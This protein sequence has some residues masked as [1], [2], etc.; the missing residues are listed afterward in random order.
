LKYGERLRKYCLSAIPGL[1]LGNGY[2]DDQGA[3][4]H[5][6][7][8]RRPCKTAQPEKIRIV[9]DLIER[10]LDGERE[11]CHDLMQGGCGH[12]TG[13]R[14]SSLK[15]GFG[16]SCDRDFLVYR[17]KQRLR[18]PLIFADRHA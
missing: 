13:K 12:Y 15:E 4:E 10:A 17:R 11:T 6:S 18:I 16:D 7:A 1:P 2:A 9:R 3:G 8:P 14:D 5:Q